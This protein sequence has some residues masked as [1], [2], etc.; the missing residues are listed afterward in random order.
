MPAGRGRRSAARLLLAV[1]ALAATL[2]GTLPAR[3]DPLEDYSDTND[4]LEQLLTER[5]ALETSVATAASA[6]RAALDRFA[7]VERTLGRL[8]YDQRGAD[9]RRLD[10]AR[11]LADADAH[12]PALDAHATQL[13][14][15]I[16]AQERW[17][18]DSMAP[19]IFSARGFVDALAAWTQVP[20]ERAAAL[21]ALGALRSEQAV[22]VLDLGRLNTEVTFWERQADSVARQVGSLRARAL[23]ATA[24]LAEVQKTALELTATA[25]DQLDALR[26]LGYPV[27]V[28]LVA[29]G[30]PPV[31]EPVP[32]PADAPR[33]YALPSGASALVLRAGEPLTGDRAQSSIT[34]VETAGWMLPVNGQVTTPFGDATPYQS[35][36]WALD[37]GTRLYDPVR[38]AADGIVEFAGLAVG[39]NRL[40]SYGM[41]VVIRHGERVTSLYAH[42]DDRAFGAAVQPGDA[43]R[44]GQVI[45]YVGL[46]GNSTGPH[47]HF[48][49]RLDTQPF[50]PLLLVGS[51]P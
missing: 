8:V 45:G 31:P 41:V 19:Q 28:A 17:L 34:A 51:A 23:T 9:A 30:L 29:E 10:L 47:V 22:V 38:A 6:E 21:Q 46:T 32:W 37:F 7:E 2:L 44:Q 16:R 11:R 36:H 42:L 12:V 15:Q 50:D 13:E 39:D 20:A 35:A 4:Q 3:A 26:R 43:V 24:R 49:A 18:N 5:D 33:G 27:G 40:A 25:Q 1:A 14:D 48:E